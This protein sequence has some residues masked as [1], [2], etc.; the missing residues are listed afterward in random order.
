MAYKGP[1]PKKNAV[2]RHKP[3]TP[4]MEVIF[5]EQ[6]KVTPR[7]LF[8]NLVNPIDRRIGKDAEDKKLCSEA[9]RFL[10]SLIDYPLTEN[11]Q[12]AQWFDLKT[13][14]ML[15]DLFLKTGDIKMLKESRSILKEYFIPSEQLLKARKQF[16][17]TEQAE[18]KIS[19]NKRLS[20]RDMYRSVEND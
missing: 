15:Y 19:E 2:T 16:A 14:V 6:T 11:L 17:V 10:D 13:S 18:Q 3:T 20:A 8:S 5:V 7:L 9:L 4:D 12:P 1:A